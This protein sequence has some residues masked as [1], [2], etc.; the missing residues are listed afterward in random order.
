MTKISEDD[1]RRLFDR[2]LEEVSPDDNWHGFK[3]GGEKISV[4]KATKRISE[5]SE[6]KKVRRQIRSQRT[7]NRKKHS[8]AI[9]QFL[10]FSFLSGIFFFIFFLLINFPGLS[11]QFEWLYYNEYLNQEIPDMTSIIVPT[12]TTA[13]TAEPTAVAQITPEPI[14]TKNKVAPETIDGELIIDKL[15]V[16]APVFWDISEGDILERLKDGVAHYKGTSRPGEGGNIFLVGHSSN[17]V[18]IKSDYNNVFALLDKLVAGDRIEIRYGD[19]SYYYDVVET[20]IVK[21]S[22]VEV[23]SGTNTETLSL[24]T[25]WPVGTSLNRLIVIAEFKYSSTWSN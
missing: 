21:P 8:G 5:Q 16:D 10:R 4:K 20:K 12:A 18:W 19:Q 6:I 9:D 11:K 7:Q 17:Y 15:K 1:L 23:L 14:I 25:C 24:M 2:E 22:Q 13:R 3:D